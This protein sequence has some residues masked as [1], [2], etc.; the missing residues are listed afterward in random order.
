MDI[1]ISWVN[2]PSDWLFFSL[3]LFLYFW[4]F[5]PCVLAFYCLQHVSCGVYQTSLLR[6]LSVEYFHIYSII[7]AFGMINREIACLSV[8]IFLSVCHQFS[9]SPISLRF[10]SH[11][12]FESE[13]CEKWK[14]IEYKSTEIVIHDF[15]WH[16]VMDIVNRYAFWRNHSLNWIKVWCGSDWCDW[17][18]NERRI[19]HCWLEKEIYCQIHFAS[20]VSFP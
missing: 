6:V 4:W 10:S 2:Y 20:N 1:V 15:Y 3:L 7:F 19:Y 11:D 16:G 9:F 13:T 8:A 14:S 18:T 17:W 12:S 5:I